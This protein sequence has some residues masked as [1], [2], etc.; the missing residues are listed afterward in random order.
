MS[1]DAD[2]ANGPLGRSGF[3][4]VFDAPPKGGYPIGSGN[5]TLTLGSEQFEAR[6]AFA[7]EASEVIDLTPF[8]LVPIDPDSLPTLGGGLDLP[9]LSVVA[10][11][12]ILKGVNVFG[13]G[14]ADVF[15]LPANGVTNA[16]GDFDP[17]DD[18]VD[19]SDWGVTDFAQL[20]LTEHH[21]GKLIVSFEDQAV[22][23]GDR[24]AP[25]AASEVSADQF[26]FA[27]AAPE[28]QEFGAGD[29]V[30]GRVVG[31][32]GGDTFNASGAHLKLIGGAG[33]DD[34]FVFAS[35]LHVHRILDFDPSEDTLF[36]GWFGVS[37]VDELDITQLGNGKVVIKSAPTGNFIGGAEKLVLGS[38]AHPVDADDL[39]EGDNM[40]FFS[41]D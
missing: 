14:G 41:V 15:I 3:R 34:F 35:G 13:G 6:H 40:Q 9:A 27:D 1:I 36:L 18:R 7:T 5:V 32:D 30:N 31:T 38:E 19:L 23:L 10:S 29:A 24:A 33:A 22:V 17:G 16:I 8:V 11:D 26:L 12:P 20:T 25:V 37:G 28:G 21:S 4:E 39:I 2:T